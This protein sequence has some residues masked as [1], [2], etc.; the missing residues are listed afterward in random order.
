MSRAPCRATI[1]AGRGR[2]G[3]KLLVK[4]VRSRPHQPTTQLEPLDGG[5]V[6]TALELGKGARKRRL[7]MRKEYKRFKCCSLSAIWE[8]RFPR[9][10]RAS[11]TSANAVSVGP[12]NRDVTRS[13]YGVEGGQQRG[14]RKAAEP[15][16]ATFL[17]FL[18]P[19]SASSP[20]SRFAGRCSL[21]PFCFCS[22]KSRKREQARRWFSRARRTSV[23]PFSCYLLVLTAVLLHCRRVLRARP[24]FEEQRA[25]FLF[26]TSSLL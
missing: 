15:P 9:A 10:G 12:E 11:D 19:S 2:R 3:S 5:A 7:G 17:A 23:W 6:Q 13:A 20:V 26:L 18:A 21:R 14:D 8:A 4:L 16:R 22:N 1:R 24:E 25:R